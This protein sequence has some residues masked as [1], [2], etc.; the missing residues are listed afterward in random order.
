M[1]KITTYSLMTSLTAI[2]ITSCSFVDHAKN[3]NE[4]MSLESLDKANPSFEEGL[5]A[6]N[7]RKYKIAVRHL[8]PLANQGNLDAKYLV[9]RM[10]IDVHFPYYSRNGRD[11]LINQGLQY[12]NEASNLGHIE[13]QIALGD[14]HNQKS[15]LVYEKERVDHKNKAIK[16]YTKAT[17]QGSAKARYILAEMHEYYSEI[18]ESKTLLLELL[19]IPDHIYKHKTKDKLLRMVEYRFLGDDKI[20]EAIGI[21]EKIGSEL[22]LKRATGLKNLKE[23]QVFGVKVYKSPM[24]DEL[25]SAMHALGAKV[26]KEDNNAW[27]DGYIIKD[28]LPNS[29]ELFLLYTGGNRLAKAAYTFHGLSFQDVK[30]IVE[31]KYSKATYDDEGYRNRESRMASWPSPG[32][33]VSLHVKQQGVGQVAIEV[34]HRENYDQYLRESEKSSNKMKYSKAF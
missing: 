5:E 18:S 23:I 2:L 26:I 9:G 7:D 6:Y 33:I 10:Y 22:A 25:R 12:L 14:Y 27:G 8:R 17:R 3:Q 15:R 34:T 4:L 16:Y 31:D 11:N 28:I 24:R 1:W 29:S 13:S 19:D 32:G 20:E 30:K 21:L